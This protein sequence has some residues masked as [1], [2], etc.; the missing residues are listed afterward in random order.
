MKTTIIALLLG[1]LS[2]FAAELATPAAELPPCCRVAVPLGKPT[3]KSLY[4]LDS[5]WTSDVGKT[6]PLSIL[7]GR[8]QVVAMF[9]STCEYACPIIVNDMKTLEAKLPT[10]VRAK[11]DFLLVSFD[12]KRDTPAV[13]A[14]YRKKEK[15]PTGNWTILRGGEDDVR[16]LAALLGINY[17]QDARGQFAHSNVITV[18]NAEGEIAFQQP[19]L[20]AAPTALVDAVGKAAMGARR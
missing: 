2:V 14:A 18:L 3:D 6:I 5:K 15:L 1:T 8:P 20:N 7:R 13:L 9:F 12:T 17:S 19:G 4:L 16:E 11:T 10:E